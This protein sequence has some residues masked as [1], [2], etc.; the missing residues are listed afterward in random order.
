MGVG[1]VEHVLERR[2]GRQE[3]A[4][5]NVGFVEGG[6]HDGGAVCRRL[7]G[8]QLAGCDERGVDGVVE[9]DGGGRWSG[10]A[11]GKSGD[12]GRVV[13]ESKHGLALGHVNGLLDG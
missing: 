5:H 2:D 12:G 1:H 13:S 8:R 11:F 7:L 4:D 9:S 6:E 10:V 3:P